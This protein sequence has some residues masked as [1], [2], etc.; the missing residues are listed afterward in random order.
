MEYKIKKAKITKGRTLE[1]ELTEKYPDN[2]ENE[3]TKKCSQLVHNDMYTAFERL[4]FHLA[5]LC[6]LKESDRARNL[7]N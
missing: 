2:T 7:E 4:K 1:V 6:D 5:H 3:V